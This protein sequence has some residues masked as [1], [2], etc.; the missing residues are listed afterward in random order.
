[1]ARSEAIKPSADLKYYANV[2]SEWTMKYGGNSGALS[3]D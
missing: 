1:M 3:W 2:G